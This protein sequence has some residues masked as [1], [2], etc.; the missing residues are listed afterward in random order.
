MVINFVLTLDMFTYEI[1][2]MLMPKIDGKGR[3]TSIQLANSSGNW[4]KYY[5]IQ[6]DSLMGELEK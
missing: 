2:N 6:K 1:V 4:V 3:I 5:D